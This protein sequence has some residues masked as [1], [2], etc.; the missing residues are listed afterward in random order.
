MK[1]QVM[2]LLSM[3]LM[4]LVLFSCGGNEKKGGKS[5]FTPV[6]SGRPYEMLV[7][8]D[9]GMW[10]RPAGRALFDVLDSDVPGLPQPERSF[11]ISQIIPSKFD[12]G[13]RIFRNI[14]D[15]DIQPIYTQPKLKYSRD[16]Y[17]SPQMIMTIQAP[18]EQSFEEFVAKNRQVIV[19]FFTKAEMNRQIN[20][21]KEKYSPVVAAKVGSI[22]G[23]DVRIPAELERYKEG[24]DFLWASSDNNSTNTSLNFV[25]YSYPYTDKNT[26]T[27]DYFVHK[28]DSVMKI[29]IPGAREGQYIQTDADYVDVKDFAVKGE[30]AFEARGLW[31]ME[32]DMMGGPFV[33]HARV[34]R[35]NGRVVV[36]EGFVYAPEKKKRDLMRKLEAALYTL[37]L[38]QEQELEEIVIKASDLEEVI[39]DTTAVK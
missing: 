2:N 21:L 5:L 4:A 38:P 14:I 9:K 31:Y 37:N 7:V 39:P 22:F 28:R 33:S 6:S 11:R 30:Y 12:R 8:I 13:F 15:V 35:P 24:K 34:D 23:C 18:D 10:E 16:S 25:I 29:N 26:F 19:D 17:A 3:A 1:K 27:K 36:V 20:L 32:N